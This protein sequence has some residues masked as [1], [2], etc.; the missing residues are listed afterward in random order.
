MEGT[1]KERSHLRGQNFGGKVCYIGRDLPPSQEL[2]HFVAKGVTVVF[3]EVVG[4]SSVH[5]RK[6]WRV[7]EKDSSICMEGLSLW[8]EWEGRQSLM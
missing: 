5:G 4:F 2:C 3:K 6:V 1:E 7:D 8:S